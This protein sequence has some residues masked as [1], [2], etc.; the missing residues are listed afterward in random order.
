MPKVHNYHKE[1][2][3][4]ERSQRLRKSKKKMRPNS[5]N[6]KPRE[7]SW[8]HMANDEWDAPGFYQDE[9]VM[10]RGT[11]E[12]QK[13]VEA[14][15]KQSIEKAGREIVWTVNDLPAGT[16]MGVVIEAVGGK[17]TVRVESKI[18]ECTVR[19]AL[20]I[21]ETTF[22]S[23]VASGDAVAVH[24]EANGTGVVEQVLPR[25][26]VLARLYRPDKGATSS[27]RQIVAANIDRVLVVTSW[28][29]PSIWPELIDRYLIAA[30]RNHLEAVICVNKVDLVEDQA[31]LE[32]TLRPYREAGYQVILTSAETGVGIAALRE[33]LKD[34]TTVFAGLSGV[35]KSS[36]LSQIQPGLT[37]KV[38]SIGERGKNRNQGRHST[39]LA[40]LYPLEQGGT[41]IDT[42]GIR[43]FGL[44]YLERKQLAGFYPEIARAVAGCEYAD[45]THTHEPNCGVKA[46]VERGSISQMR[47]DSY[48]KILCTLE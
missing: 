36:L 29:K 5:N 31:E 38:L 42:P 19:R 15:A 35:G 46:A 4:H 27:L 28:R 13:V 6:R 1:M 9:R 8:E 11:E 40:T 2:E 24:S 44:S 12:R 43:E 22:T 48:Q 32:T 20:L 7:R 41:V 16:R 34:S 14:M 10:P 3:K 33:L 18:L 23:V 25:R 30:E 47:Y 45:C 37:L 17:C 21:E 26:S 39:T